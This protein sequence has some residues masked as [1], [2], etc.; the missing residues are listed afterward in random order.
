MTVNL[1]SYKVSVAGQQI[2][3][4]GP[5]EYRLEGVGV[6]EQ[7]KSGSNRGQTPRCQQGI[8]QKNGHQLN[9]SYLRRSLE[10]FVMSLI[11]GETEVLEITG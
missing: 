11:P 5:K 6:T 3:E 9:S 1:R 10:R 4:E 7:S 8:D 2:A